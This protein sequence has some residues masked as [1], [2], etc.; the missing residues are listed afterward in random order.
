[1][2]A[3][4]KYFWKIFVA[5]ILINSASIGNIEQGYTITDCRWVPRIP[6][7]LEYALYQSF[8]YF[9]HNLSINGKFTIP[10]V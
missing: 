7:L 4:G 5:N 1:M 6:N 8:H 3:Y 10:L 2:V 9:F